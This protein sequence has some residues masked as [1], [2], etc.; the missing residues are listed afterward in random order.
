MLH[1]ATAHFAIVLPVISLIIGLAYLVKPS[2]VMSK[3]STRFM[4]ASAIFIIIAFFTGKNDGGEVYMFI[5][6][7]GQKLL[8]EHKQLGLYLAIAMGAVA[9]VKLYGC[10]TK[11]FKAELLA[12]VLVAFISGG[13]LYQGKMGGDLTYTYGSHVLKH[14]DGMDC[15]DD[16]EEFLED[17]E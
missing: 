5:S 12:V 9:L 16:P 13:V 3:L 17:E 8:I 2:E 1:P 7:E 4:L 14:S 11:T 15:L 6:G 10:I